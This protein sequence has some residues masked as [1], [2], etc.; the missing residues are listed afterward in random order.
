MKNSP[1]FMEPNPPLDSF[2]KA[3]S[4]TTSNLVSLIGLRSLLNTLFE[5]DYPTTVEN[6]KVNKADRQPKTTYPSP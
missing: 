6:G 5:V 3:E 1:P 4:P 2:S